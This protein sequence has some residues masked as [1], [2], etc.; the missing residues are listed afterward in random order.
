LVRER[1]NSRTYSWDMLARSRLPN[2]DVKRLRTNAQVL[3]VFFL[4]LAWWYCR[5]ESTARDTFMV[6]LLWLGLWAE[7]A[8]LEVYTMGK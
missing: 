1:R 4:E 5:W 7:N 6:H 3:T 2:L 8:M